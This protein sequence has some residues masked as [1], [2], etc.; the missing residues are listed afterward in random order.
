MFRNERLELKV[1][2]FIGVGIFLMFLI[3]FSIKDLYMFKKGYDIQVLFDYVNGI[4][5]NA[6]VRVS[7]VHTG[8]VKDIE[9][10]YDKDAG[11]MRVKL[12]V[13]IDEK[14][15]I[16]EDAE[17][18]INTLGL[19]GEQYLE[20]TPGTGK[21]FLQ[22]GDVVIGTNP[23]SISNQVETMNEFVMSVSEVIKHIEEGKGTLGK[24]LV[25]ET[26][27]NNINSVFSKINTAEGT[28]GKLLLEDDIYKDLKSFVNDIKDHPW[29]LLHKPK[30]SV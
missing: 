25:D 6:P 22:F 14:V 8:E 9:I 7:G 5:K 15:K 20:I 11:R 12:Y 30:N 10:Y 27:Y 2:L 28:L 21:R 24:L 16:E 3:V 19:L 13:W 1:G 17:F 18:S 4:G 26:L 29:K 23:I